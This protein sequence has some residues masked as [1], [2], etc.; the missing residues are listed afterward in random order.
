MNLAEIEQ[1]VAELDVA[2][3]FDLIYDL[4]LAYGLPKASVSRLRSGTYNKST[5]AN[6][7]LWKGRVYF[8]HVDTGEDLHGLIDDARR[9]AIARSRRLS[10][11][12]AGSSS[13]PRFFLASTYT[14]ATMP[15]A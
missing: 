15:P 9:S 13:P 11:C 7:A 4:L 10:G 8:R 1:Q 6:E 5:A 12:D 2:Q 3:G 14:A